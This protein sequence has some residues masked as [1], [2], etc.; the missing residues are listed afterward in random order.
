MSNKLVSIV[1]PAYNAEPYLAAAIESV[2]SQTYPAWEL[3][4]VND[5]STDETPA[6][7]ERFQRLDERIKVFTQSENTGV[8]KARNSAL[9]QAKGK[10]IAFLDSDDLWVPNKLEKQIA[11]MLANQVIIS[12]GAY[13]RIDERGNN[14]G[15]VWPLKELDYATLLKSNF[16]GNLTGVYDAEMLGKEC[17]GDFRHE[18]YVAWLALVKRAGKAMSVDE[19]LGSYRVYTGSASSNKLKAALWQW[20]IYRQSQLLGIPQS[21][22]LMLHYFYHAIHKRV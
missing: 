13:Q 22:W 4:I 2:I 6:I 11:F 10:Y 5:A 20:R 16:I 7:A 15:T 14:L 18:D 12:Y 17:F 19:V 9:E 8:A 3:L 21:C 1:M